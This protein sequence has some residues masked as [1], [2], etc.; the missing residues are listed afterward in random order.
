MET[1]CQGLLV[2]SV[3][4]PLPNYNSAE[5]LFN[6]SI[7]WA[8]FASLGRARPP[9]LTCHDCDFPEMQH[10]SGS[11]SR[12]SV[13]RQAEISPQSSIGVFVS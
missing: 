3:R 1:Q 11:M 2:K 13:A 8:F 5:S 12:R 7:Q 6:S 4:F 9:L 10:W